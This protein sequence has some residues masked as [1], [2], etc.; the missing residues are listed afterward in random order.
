MEERRFCR[1]GDHVFVVNSVLADALRWSTSE[2]SL[3]TIIIF[4][5]KSFVHAVYNPYPTDMTVI[6]LRQTAV[7]I[8]VD[9][10][11]F[12]FWVPCQ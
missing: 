5:C 1:E 3:F 2:S 7:D 8:T 4:E 9:K 12:V 10:Q 11:L 6:A